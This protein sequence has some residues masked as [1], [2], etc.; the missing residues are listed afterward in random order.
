MRLNGK[1]LNTFFHCNAL[2]E[3]IDCIS[4]SGRQMVNLAYGINMSFMGHNTSTLEH[5]QSMLKQR[6]GE[7][8]HIQW[9]LARLQEGRSVLAEEIAMLTTELEAV[10]NYV[11]NMKYFFT[12][13]TLFL[14]CWFFQRQRKSCSPTKRWIKA[15]RSSSITMMRCCK[16]TVRKL[17]A[18]KN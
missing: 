13:K 8:A 12:I 6:D 7:L 4:N 18:P 14:F 17:N 9:E 16:C 2:Q 15:T 1:Q 3:D 10:S 5:L 11:Y